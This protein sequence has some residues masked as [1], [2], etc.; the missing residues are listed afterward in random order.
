[1]SRFGAGLE[2]VRRRL[3]AVDADGCL[4]VGADCA[5]AVWRLTPGDA[6]LARLRTRGDEAAVI[7]GARPFHRQQHRAAPLAADADPLDKADGGENDRAPNADHVAQLGVPAGL[8]L[9][10]SAVLFFNWFA[11]DQFLVW[12]WRIPFLLSIVMAGVGLYIRLGILETPI[13]TQLVKEKRI[14]RTPVLEVIRRQ[15]KEII[16]CA[17]AKTA[18]TAPAY[19]Y[20]A[21]VFVYGTQVLHA[22]REFLLSALIAACGLAF[23]VIPFS[24]YFSDR[25]GRKRMY[26]IGAVATGIFGFVYFATLNSLVPALM[27]LAVMLSFVPHGLIFGPQA[28]LF[29]ECF[30]PRLRYSGTSIGFHLAAV[31]A[32]G[33]APLIATALLAWTGSGYA[34]AA[35]IAATAIVSIAATLLLPDHTNKDISHEHV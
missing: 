2:D 10:Y 28:A 18:E 14:E 3:H 23:F 26:M 9:A 16:L 12:G 22:S 19:V 30:T 11:G 5:I 24:G 35:Y 32:G 20:I 8:L 33:P 31:T 25:I 4:Y 21:F 6:W 34:I 15:P 13:F 7:V 17:L 29:A 1:V 27:F